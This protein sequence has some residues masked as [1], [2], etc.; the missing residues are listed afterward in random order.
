MMIKYPT[1]LGP[2]NMAEVTF[3]TPYNLVGKVDGNNCHWD[4]DGFCHHDFLLS[5]SLTDETMESR[6]ERLPIQIQNQIMDL[7]AEN[8]DEQAIILFKAHDVPAKPH[9]HIPSLI[10]VAMFFLFIALVH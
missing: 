6:F 3:Q 7:W 4:E 8:K 9:W 1:V 2:L 10:I 5:F